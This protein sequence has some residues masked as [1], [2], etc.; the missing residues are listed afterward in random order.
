MLFDPAANR[1]VMYGGDGGTSNAFSPLGDRWQFHFASQ[2]WSRLPDSGCRPPA[3]W[4]TSF[5]LDQV[6]EKAYL[7]GGSGR[8]VR[9]DPSLYELD[10]RTDTWKRLQTSGSQPPSLQGATMTFD[11]ARRVL[12]V[13]GGLKHLGLAPATLSKVWIFDPAV[14]QWDEIDGGEQLRRRDHL[15]AYDLV[16]GQH[17]LV[18]GRVSNEVGNF[19]RRGVMAPVN[20]CIQ[21]LPAPV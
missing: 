19:F 5:A 18:G 15:G 3:R 11:D 4:H 8:R 16:S 12:V 2:R 10:L 13:A 20:V 1:L 14:N 6:K 17:I 7:F 21:I 9:Y